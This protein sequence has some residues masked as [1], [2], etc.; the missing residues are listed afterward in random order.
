MAEWKELGGYVCPIYQECNPSHS[1]SFRIREAIAVR[2]D[3]TKWTEQV[4]LFAQ[5]VNTYG[6]V[7]IVVANAG[8]GEI[9]QFETFDDV[10]TKEPSKPNLATT[11]INIV[12]V[13]YSEL[14][15]ECLH[16]SLS[17]NNLS[18]ARLAMFHF[19][20]NPR[21]H[22]ALVL[23]GSVGMH[24]FQRCY[25]THANFYQASIMGLPMGPMYGH[26]KHAVS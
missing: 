1:I 17:T 2:S 3:V 24:F 8:V 14:A 5:A 13:L 18:A 20:K 7:D 21:E 26:S 15:P 22:K 23:I 9:G 10:K 4:E 19:R 11:Q 6:A 12:G 25:G 16:C